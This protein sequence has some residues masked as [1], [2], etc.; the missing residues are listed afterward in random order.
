MDTKRITKFD[1]FFYRYGFE[2]NGH[3]NQPQAAR[4]ARELYNFIVLHRLLS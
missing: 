3:P 4:M 2:V 1:T